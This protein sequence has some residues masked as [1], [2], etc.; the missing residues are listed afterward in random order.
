LHQ[1]DNLDS[2]RARLIR[3]PIYRCHTGKWQ[4]GFLRL[5]E[6]FLQENRCWM[7]EWSV[8]VTWTVFK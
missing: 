3:P 4:M 2:E 6:W 5:R 1:P 8:I 7:I